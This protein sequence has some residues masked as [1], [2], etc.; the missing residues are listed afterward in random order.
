M[1]TQSAAKTFS[2]KYLKTIGICN[3]DADGRGFGNPS[4]LVVSKDGRIFVLNRGEPDLSRVGVCNL[5]ED[6][7]YEFGTHGDGDGQFRLPSALALDSRERVYVADEYNHRISVFESSGEYVGRWGE[8]GAGDGQID[9][10]SGLA[11]DAEDNVYMVDQNNNRIQKFTSDGRYLL[12]WGEFGGGEGQLNLPWGITLDAHGDVYVADW[13]ND[14]IQKFTPDGLYVA[15]YGE[16]GDGD[17]QFHRPAGVVVDEDGNMYVADWG[18]E[19]VQVLGPEGGFLVML[20]GQA[21]ESKWAADYFT[22]N[23]EEKRLRDVSNLTPELP[24]HLDT[25]YLLASHAEPHFFGPASVELDGHG[26]L[27]VTEK[28]R[29]RVQVYQRA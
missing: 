19:R 27:Y 1:G 2:L 24:S 3:V 11:F 28:S 18:N 9:G 22:S 20:E 6:Y 23:W 7:L 16:S 26:R 13:R 12:Q 10:P 17:G 14:R 5:D 15:E 8:F 21:T 4:G 25:R 29:Y